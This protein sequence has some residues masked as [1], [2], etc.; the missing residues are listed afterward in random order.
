MH[1]GCG[2]AHYKTAEATSFEKAMPLFTS[3]WLSPSLW[4]LQSFSEAALKT[5][6]STRAEGALRLKAL[7]GH[8]PSMRSVFWVPLHL[9][10]KAD[11]LMLWYC[12]GSPEHLCSVLKFLWTIW[13]SAPQKPALKTPHQPDHQ[14]WCA[15]VTWTAQEALA[16]LAAFLSYFTLSEALSLPLSAGGSGISLCK[17]C[18]LLTAA[19]GSPSVAALGSSSQQKLTTHGCSTSKQPP[20]SAAHSSLPKRLPWSFA[21]P[22]PISWLESLKVSC[23]SR[24]L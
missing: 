21:P 15:Q 17:G 14:P 7:L 4:Y 5:F 3:P 12:K 2:V 9:L 20:A 1:P 6:N 10:E 19:L 24:Q 23:P 8:I 11:T 18:S 13:S 16:L 22:I